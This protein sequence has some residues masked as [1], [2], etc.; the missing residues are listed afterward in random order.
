[1]LVS[2]LPDLKMLRPESLT[3]DD[4]RR[5]GFRA[6]LECHIQLET[7][8]K[9][10]CHCRPEVLI[11]KKAD[12]TFSRFFRPVLGEMGDYDEG[13]LIE[14]EK[15][16]LVKYVAH[17]SPHNC[18]Y[19]Q[20]EQPPHWPA[21]EAYEIGLQLAVLFHMTALVDEIQVSRKQ[22]LDGSITTGF[23][24]TSIVGKDGWVPLRS[25]KKVRITNLLIEEDSARKVRAEDRDGA[26]GRTVWYNLDRLGIPLTEII[27]DCDDIGDPDELREA[28]F[29][30]G[31]VLRLNKLGK[32]GIGTA[33]Q[34]VNISIDDELSNRVELKGVQDLGSFRKYSQREVVRQ[35]ML[36]RIA[37][38]LRRR[39]AASNGK[40]KE[41]LEHTYVDLTHLAEGVLDPEHVMMG[42]AL[43]GFKDL[44]GLEIQPK[45]DF[46]HDM[47]EKAEL[48][49]GVPREWIYHSDE[50]KPDAVRR[51]VPDDSKGGLPFSLVDNHLT[52]IDEAFVGLKE[53]NSG[54]F[55]VFGP[56]TRVIHAL[57]KL[58]E[59]SKSAYDGVTLET[60]SVLSSGNSE[61]L[62]VIHGKDRLYPD[63]DQPFI[64]LDPELL[65]R[66]KKEFGVRPWD[67][68]AQLHKDHCIERDVVER[69]IRANWMDVF[70][71][72]LTL[73]NGVPSGR[74]VALFML[75]EL[76]HVAREGGDVGQLTA[77]Q[78]LEL[79]GGICSRFPSSQLAEICEL[80]NAD[81][82]CSLDSITHLVV[83][84]EPVTD[85]RLEG[86]LNDEW[87]QFND[88][89]KHEI[90][91]NGGNVLSP[92]FAQLVGR[93]VERTDREAGGK[94]IVEFLKSRIP[95]LIIKEEGS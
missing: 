76:K 38:E 13:M 23:Q 33:R 54:Y 51:E 81:P 12:Y 17:D 94:R 74:K 14:F 65:K 15:G 40:Q 5:L 1:M 32:R 37:R 62:R 4:F 68:A 50:A 87:L 27:T 53:L 49:T 60:R 70:L 42:V 6:G 36:C 35:E 71:E 39:D 59:R 77:K 55:V 86:I 22:Y 31:L 75:N 90:A 2:D 7:S 63:T 93:L 16:Y 66:I 44:L 84:G 9:L 72:T 10:F 26:R 57:K 21:M 20:D 46:G 25:G 83:T 79:A 48:I 8:R 58:V 19:E 61:F 34:D 18:L 85:H 43:P 64:P 88:E 78:I 73:G 41:A 92:L 89:E 91:D 47:I 30:I 28:A 69:L 95:T 29:Q 80:M 52:A 82:N 56:Q 45:K 11:G 3:N 67:L 24:R